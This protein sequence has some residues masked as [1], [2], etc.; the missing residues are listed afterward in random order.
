[1]LALATKFI[2]AYVSDRRTAPY[3][4]GMALQVAEKLQ[5]A[6]IEKVKRTTAQLNSQNMGSE[7]DAAYQ[8]LMHNDTPVDLM[9]ASAERFP[10]NNRRQIY[11][12]ASNKLLGQGNWHA[13]REI[14]SENFA[15]EDRDQMLSNF[16]QQRAYN[17]IGQTKFTEAEQVIDGLPDQQRIGLLVYLA[18]NV[19]SRDPKENSDYA[20]AL[21]EKAR[22]LTNEKP[23]NSNE[24]ST[25]MQVVGGYGNIDPAEAIRLYEGIVPKIVELTDASAVLNGFQVNSNV[26]DGEFI[27]VNGDPFNQYGGNASISAFGKVDLDRTLRL[28]DSFNRREMRISLRLQLLDGSELVTSG[29][30]SSGT[31]A[32]LI[33]RRRGR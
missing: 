22:Q 31:S 8:K 19:M 11:Q 30:V 23:E 27:M 15:D 16:D 3:V 1:M 28:I 6:S 24:M 20:K 10:L 5:P 21:L 13:A 12:T 7:V 2:S 18:N 25:L 14:L 9:L 32:P 26:R 17:L 29:P 33:V 4:G